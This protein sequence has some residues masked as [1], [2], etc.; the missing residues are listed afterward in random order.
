MGIY[1]K[2]KSGAECLD[3]SFNLV[4]TAMYNS[5]SNYYIMN[6]TTTNSG[7]AW[8]NKVWDDIGLTY[9]R[10]TSTYQNYFIVPLSGIL[11][12]QC[13]MAFLS[14]GPSALTMLAANLLR[15]DIT[16]Y[17]LYSR[18]SQYLGASFTWF[19][20]VNKGD[21][22]K[23]L[24]AQVSGQSITCSGQSSRLNFLLFS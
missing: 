18:V 4:K 21:K 11:I 8:D 23:V 1:V 20:K 9:V 13:Y 12:I 10:D 19:Q 17:T 5:S 2:T 6:T 14:D 24:L 3:H 7:T 15:N 16:Q 22:L